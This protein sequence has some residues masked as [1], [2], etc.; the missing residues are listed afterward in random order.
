MDSGN[1]D[2]TIVGRVLTSAIVKLGNDDLELQIKTPYLSLDKSNGNTLINVSDIDTVNLDLKNSTTTIKYSS[3][4]AG[5]IIAV[6]S[7]ITAQNIISNVNWKLTNSDLKATKIKFIENS[8]KLFN[9]VNS[10]IKLA[11]VR[12]KPVTGG[13][14][15]LPYT[16][17]TSSKLSKRVNK[18]TG[19]V[20]LL[21]QI[22]QNRRK[23]FIQC[24]TL[25]FNVVNGIIKVNH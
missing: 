3:F 22:T 24:S 8:S 18:I 7:P 19:K 10:D 12:C 6:N 4:R 5:K 15:S 13:I 17:R 23:K 16:T 2:V 9:G 20:N 25:N 1:S 14:S 11:S 21:K